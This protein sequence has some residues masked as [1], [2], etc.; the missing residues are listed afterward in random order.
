MQTFQLFGQ[1]ISILECIGFAFGIIGVWL[2]IKQNILCFPVGIINVAIYAFIFFDP[3][4]TLYLNAVL[5]LV[6]IV[7][8][9]YGWIHWKSKTT[10]D[11]LPITN[12]VKGS[13][14]I[15][16]IIGVT[17]SMV[18]GYIMKEH[19]DARLPYWD[20]ITTCISLI[21]QWMI[22]KKKIENWLLWIMADIMLV[23]M[24]IYLFNYLTALLYFIY[25]IL[26]IK[27]YMEWKKA[28]QTSV[29]LH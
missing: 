12:T 23:G 9:I 1:Q 20:A 14:F 2:T 17:T 8:L 6:Y 18:C 13:G 22:A 27:G 4:S 28:K 11:E 3:K 29:V 10:S 5:Q 19:T 26:A 7:L 25:F 15:L 21:A 24:N 16:F